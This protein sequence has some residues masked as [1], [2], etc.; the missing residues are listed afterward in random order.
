MMPML[1]LERRFLKIT[2]GDEFE[3]LDIDEVQA[4]LNDANI[5]SIDESEVA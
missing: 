5:D 3:E 2:V 1:W 4:L